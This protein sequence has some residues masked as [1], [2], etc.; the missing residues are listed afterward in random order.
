MA[1]EPRRILVPT[2]FSAASDRAISLARDLAGRFDAEIHPLHVRELTLDPLVER[3]MLDEVER[4]LQPGAD[5]AERSLQEIAETGGGLKWVP[6]VEHGASI[7]DAILD[8]IAE[9]GCDLVIIG[10]HGRRPFTEFLMGSVARRVVRL[11]QVPVISTH[12]EVNGRFPPRKILVAYDSSEDSLEA[13][14]FAREWSVAFGARVVL[15]HVVEN[16]VYPGFYAVEAVGGAY[17]D[18]LESDCR[19]ALERAASEFLSG[20]DAECVVVH[21]NAAR[22]ITG[23]AGDH[24][25]DLV[26]LATRG[27]SGIEHILMGSVAVRVVRTATVPVLTVRS[28]IVEGD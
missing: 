10:T 19:A 3:A 1:T 5:R 8:S 23:Y 11:S 16:V 17:V 25:C 28:A 20:V 9:Y 2:D 21:D 13:V 7:A 14:R 26:V 18:N 6:H 27:L 24:G 4:V 15:L 12:A 22:G